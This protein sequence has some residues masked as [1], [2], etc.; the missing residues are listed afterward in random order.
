MSISI[1]PETSQTTGAT[2]RTGPNW[3]LDPNA[4][5]L[6]QCPNCNH[7]LTAA[8]TGFSCDNESCGRVFPVTD[9]IPILVEPE[10]SIFDWQTF[11]HREPTFFRPTPSWRRL[12]S[13]MVPDLSRNIVAASE[14][15]RLKELLGKR[16]GVANVLVIGGGVVGSGMECLLDDPQIRLIE[17]DVAIAPRTQL[18]CDAHDLP[19]RDQTIDAVIVQAV[20]EHVVDPHRCVAEIHRVLKPEGLVYADTPFMQQVHGRQFDFTRFTRLGHRRLF[21]HFEEVSS[22]ISCGPGVAL[23]WSLRYFLMSWSDSQRYRALASGVARSLFWWLKYCDRFLA[24]RNASFDAASAFFFLGRKSN[25]PLDDRQLL[26]Q[27]RGGQ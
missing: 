27:Y 26:T 6:L 4:F 24:K 12:I 18:I 11:T 19:F 10:K 17:T 2:H 9:G 25:Q 7:A 1:E 3:K 22:G 16:E 14:Y 21:R 8:P 20:L 23:A 5:E 13:G 15:N